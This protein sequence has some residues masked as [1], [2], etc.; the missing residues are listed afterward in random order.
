[1]HYLNE[2]VAHAL[3]EFIT[4]NEMV[5]SSANAAKLYA[6]HADVTPLMDLGAKAHLAFKDHP[7]AVVV[8]V[9]SLVTHKNQ[10]DDIKYQKGLK[11]H[12]VTTAAKFMAKAIAGEAERRDPISVRDNGN[13]TYE[14]LD[15]NA[16]SQAAMMAGWDDMPVLIQGQDDMSR[17]NE[18]VA[19]A[20]KE[21]GIK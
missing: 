8:P 5:V 1:M 18:S 15:G 14:V 3:Q 9:D 6:D 12:P 21:M 4:I 11:A 13:G 7:E 19:F 17:I 10:N 16:T 2:S 20:V